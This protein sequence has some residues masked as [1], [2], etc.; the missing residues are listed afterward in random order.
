MPNGMSA[1]GKVSELLVVPMNG[2]T[3][4]AGSLTTAG[5][6]A[7]WAT[8]APAVTAAA[9]ATATRKASLGRGLDIAVSVAILLRIL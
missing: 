4:D 9:V 1:P 6:A 8:G 3:S 5:R 2:L 7:A